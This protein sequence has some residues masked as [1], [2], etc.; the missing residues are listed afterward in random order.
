M[1]YRVLGKSNFK[2]SEIGLGAWHIGGYIPDYKSNIG[3]RFNKKNAEKIINTA[4]DKGINFIDTADAYAD[5]NSEKIIG[6]VLKKR[7]E[8]VYVA[9]KIGSSLN[10]DE[11]NYNRKN[12]EYLIDKCLKNMDVEKIDLLQL[13]VPPNEVYYNPE[14]FEILEIMRQKGKIIHYGASIRK[15]EQGLKAIEYEGLVSLQVIYNIFRQRPFEL[16]FKESSKK[17]VG[18]IVR[19]PLASGLLTGKFNRNTKFGKDDH[20]LYNRS[21][22]KFERGETFAGVDYEQGLLAVEELKKVFNTDNLT[23][24]SIKWILMNAEVS[25]VIAGASKSEQIETNSK[26]S[27]IPPIDSKKMNQVSDIYNKYIKKYVHHY[28]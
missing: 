25:T 21:G 8:R 2:V 14:V 15:V 27:D 11:N 16:L 26:I 17:N 24:Y 7:K 18:I 3:G 19:L 9:T 10:P 12:I 23:P 5:G 13:H 4:I 20:R 22:S 6:E 28:W 1:E